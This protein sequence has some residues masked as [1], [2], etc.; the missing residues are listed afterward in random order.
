[1][2]ISV[3][4]EYA[5]QAIFD[6]ASQRWPRARQDRRHRAPA[7]DSAKISGID[8]RQPQAGRLRRIAPR[9]R[10]RLSAGAPPG[11][12]HRGRSAAFRRRPAG[13][14]LAPAAIKRF[15]AVRPLGARGQGHGLAFSTPPLS[16]NWSATGPRNTAV[17]FQT[18]RSECTSTTI[19]S[20]SA[21]RRW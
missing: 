18:G 14:A 15:A 11:S 21:A 16:P 7:E 13:R 1:M 4:G 20:A 8:S 3:K 2:N 6:L 10:R 9:R 12:H 17:S 5:L 19:H